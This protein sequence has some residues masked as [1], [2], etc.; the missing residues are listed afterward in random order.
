MIKIKIDWWKVRTLVQEDNSRFDVLMVSDR[1][2]SFKEKSLD[3]VL[4]DRGY[5]TYESYINNIEEL[6]QWIIDHCDIEV[7]KPMNF[8]DNGIISISNVQKALQTYQLHLPNNDLLNYEEVRAHED[9]CTDTL[10]GYLDDG[11][12]M[13]AVIPQVNQRRPDYILGR[14]LKIT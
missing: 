12:R 13:I 1:G 11:W 8:S 7:I 4:N 9:L 6:P 5:A 14:K 10:Q 3:D 2:Q